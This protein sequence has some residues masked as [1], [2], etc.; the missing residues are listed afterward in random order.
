MMMIYG[1]TV[2]KKSI[3]LLKL[4]KI[5]TLYKV[6]SINKKEEKLSEINLITIMKLKNY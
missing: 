6:W 1:Q 4:K 3:E 2:F 5:K